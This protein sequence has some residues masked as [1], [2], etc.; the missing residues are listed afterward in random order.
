MTATAAISVRG[1]RK[2][3]KDVPVLQGVD[4]EVIPGTIFAHSAL[5]C[6]QS[7]SSISKLTTGKKLHLDSTPIRALLGD[8][9]AEF[10]EAFLDNYAG[11]S[12]IRK[13][14]ARLSKSIDEA[15]IRRSTSFRARFD[16]ASIA[17]VVRPTPC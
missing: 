10:A 1:I 5:D 14:R 16:P 2:S 12:W 15:S 7:P 8:D 3:F 17:S 9:P 11:G 6:S 13:E 4:F